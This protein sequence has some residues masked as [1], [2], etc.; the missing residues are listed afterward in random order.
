MP[1]AESVV[2][3]HAFLPSTDRRVHSRAPLNGPV[4]VDSLED[5]HRA[6]CEDVSVGGVGVIDAGPLEIGKTV[7]VYF[8]LPSGVAVETRACVVRTNRDRVG[9][10]FI[11]LD[12]DTELALRAHCRAAS[13]R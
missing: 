8:E 11:G 5:W 7:E 4:L 13:A 9:L 6:R 1:T 2:R 10:R 3:P 12:R